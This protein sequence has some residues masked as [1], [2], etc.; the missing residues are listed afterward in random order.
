MSAK[1]PQIDPREVLR[2]EIAALPGRKGSRGTTVAVDFRSGAYGA[3]I[4]AAKARR[5]SVPAYIR[6]AA[7]AMAAHDLGIDVRDLFVRDPRVSRE[8]KFGSWAITG[9][10]GKDS[11]DV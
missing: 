9:L 7:Y 8:T 4:A 1:G 5:M 11:A 10:A 2:A 6:R 3:L